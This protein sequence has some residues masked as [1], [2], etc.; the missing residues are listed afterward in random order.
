MRQCQR[1]RC[2]DCAASAE[3]AA[4]HRDCYQLFMR[5]CTSEEALERLWIATAWRMPW[6]EAST[7]LHDYTRAVPP[8]SLACKAYGVSR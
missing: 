1:S 4:I 6:R 2:Q 7:L 3:S 8:A 5:D